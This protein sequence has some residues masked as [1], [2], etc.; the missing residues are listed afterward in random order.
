MLQN[1]I[2][3]SIVNC[4]YLKSTFYRESH[5]NDWVQF[6]SKSQTKFEFFE[7]SIGTEFKSPERVHTSLFDFITQPLPCA[8]IAS[9]LL[10]VVSTT[11]KVVCKAI[12]AGTTVG[13]EYRGES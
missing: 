11:I 8:L 1:I 7:R 4:N 2:F 13:A 10:E 6:N 5:L 9:C 3:L 12:K